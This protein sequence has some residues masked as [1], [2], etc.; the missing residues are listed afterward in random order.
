MMY[1]FTESSKLCTYVEVVVVVVEVCGR[2]QCTTLPIL[3]AQG[4][5]WP[6]QVETQL[7]RAHKHR[8]NTFK[9]IDTYRRCNRIINW[10]RVNPNR[11][12]ATTHL[13]PVSSARE[14]RV[15]ARDDDVLRGCVSIYR[16]M[17]R[18]NPRATIT[19]SS[20]LEPSEKEAQSETLAYA[21]FDGHHIARVTEDARV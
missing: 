1:R 8:S 15:R 6:L 14:F 16:A 11:S 4:V 10:T 7:P 17:W 20:V 2:C 5:Q 9:S 19:L 3:I 21:E 13:C 12:K 18:C